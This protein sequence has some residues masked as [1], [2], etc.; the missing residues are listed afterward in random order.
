MKPL[1]LKFFLD[2][3]DN[4][5]NRALEMNPL[6]KVVKAKRGRP[7]KGKTRALIDRLATHKASV[8]LFIIDFEVP[9]TN[10]QAERDIRMTKIKK[11]IAGTFRTIDGADTFIKITSYISTLSKNGIGAFNAILEAIKGHSVQLLISVTE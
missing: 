5:I 2:T 6:P 8:Y 3:Y 9:F 1:Y 4:I 10:N 7:A 11:K